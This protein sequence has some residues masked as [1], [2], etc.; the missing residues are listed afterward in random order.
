MDRSENGMKIAPINMNH[1]DEPSKPLC[2]YIKLDATHTPWYDIRYHWNV[3]QMFK[4]YKMRFAWCPSKVI[5]ISFQLIYSILLGNPILRYNY[6]TI[7]CLLFGCLLVWLLK[8]IEIFIF[9]VI[10]LFATHTHGGQQPKYPNRTLFHYISWIHDKLHNF[11][12]K[13]LWAWIFHQSWH[14]AALKYK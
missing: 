7:V 6:W 11:V 1:E 13:L 9:S 5:L 12:T 2:W 8:C 4:E 3:F 14:N 10:H